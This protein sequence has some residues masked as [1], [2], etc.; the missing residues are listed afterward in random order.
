MQNKFI[1][2]DSE[3]SCSKTVLQEVGISEDCL[4]LNIYAP[5]SLFYEGNFLLIPIVVFFHGGSFISGSGSDDVYDPFVFVGTT[6]VI[7]ITVNFRLGV[8]GSLYLSESDANGN[9]A[10]LD[11]HLALK[12]IHDNA[13]YFKGDNSKVTL[14]GHGT[15]AYSV[16]HHLFYKPSN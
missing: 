5:S 8:F 10:L 13:Y 1:L 4:Y 3:M 6:N 9:Q 11:Q 7:I 12:W 16:G 14:M 15:G 2:D